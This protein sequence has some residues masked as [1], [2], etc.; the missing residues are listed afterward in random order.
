MKIRKMHFTRIHP[1]FGELCDQDVNDSLRYDVAFRSDIDPNIVVFPVFDTKGGDLGGTVTFDRWRS[2]GILID[3]VT[4][5]DTYEL[6]ER[7]VHPEK[8]RTYRHV[9]PNYKDL[10]EFTLGQFI[11]FKDTRDMEEHWRQEQRLKGVQA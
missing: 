5:K 7:I 2:H 4:D 10:V 11:Q 8:L 3:Y 9:P 1:R 6:R